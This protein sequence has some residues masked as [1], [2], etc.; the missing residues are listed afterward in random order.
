MASE[1]KA[2]LGAVGRGEVWQFDPDKLI[3]VDTPGHPLFDKRGHL[4]PDEGLVQSFL[5]GHGQI[6]T[7]RVVYDGKDENGNPRVLVADGR[8]RVKAMREANRRRRAEMGAEAPVMNVRGEV[9][10]GDDMKLRI[11]KIA[12][13]ELRRPDPPIL[14]AE[15]AQE[16]LDNGLPMEQLPA[17]FGVGI[18]TIKKW[19]SLLNLADPIKAELVKGVVSTEAAALLIDLPRE[20]Q[21]TKYEVMKA[22]G[23]LRGREGLEAAEAATERL[24]PTRPKN[25]NVL[26]PKGKRD[27]EALLETLQTHPEDSHPKPVR[28]LKWILGTGK[29]GKKWV[30]GD[31][32]EES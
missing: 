15:K 13:N 23:T 31:D 1:Q 14:K 9:S 3:I 12:A 5:A 24:R 2:Q 19:L 26:R 32:E 7:I 29:L 17:V 11:W 18:Q 27:I 10:R 16:L 4:P 22:E 6:M 21:V 20:E 8:Q 30:G 25:P 28:I